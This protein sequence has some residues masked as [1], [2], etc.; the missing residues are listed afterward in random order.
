MRG[1]AF[2]A[3]LGMRASVLPS[4]SLDSFE[5]ELTTL[6]EGEAALLEDLPPDTAYTWFGDNTRSLFVARRGDAGT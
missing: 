1:F 5:N 4:L 2:H 3:R 6:L